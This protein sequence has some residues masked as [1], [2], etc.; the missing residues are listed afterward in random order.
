MSECNQ[1][2]INGLLE[3]IMAPA[4]RKQPKKP[5]LDVIEGGNGAVEAAIAAVKRAFRIA[6]VIVKRALKFAKNAIKFAKNLAAKAGKFLKNIPG[7]KNV[8]GKIGQFGGKI[9]GAGKNLLGAGTVSYTHL[10]LPTK[11]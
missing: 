10:T 1:S 9:L 5:M 4:K 3:K 6:R 7:V 2:S 11:A 8:V